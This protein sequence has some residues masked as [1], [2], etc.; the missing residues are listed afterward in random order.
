[1]H[2]VPKPRASQGELNTMYPLCLSH[3]IL[4]GDLQGASVHGTHAWGFYLF[5]CLFA[6][7]LN[8]AILLDFLSKATGSDTVVSCLELLI[9]SRMGAGNDSTGVGCTVP[10]RI[11]EP[12]GCPGTHKHQQLGNS[13]GVQVDGAGKAGRGILAALRCNAVQCR[14]C[15]YHLCARI[16][17]FSRRRKTLGCCLNY[18]KTKQ[19]NI[20]TGAPLKACRT[21]HLAV[22]FWQK[23]GPRTST[24]RKITSQPDRCP[25]LA[26]D[27][28][29]SLCI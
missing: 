23:W 27:F 13:Q 18:N 14:G 4:Q 8:I 9:I 22:L 17:I 24:P 11:R 29:S 6:S 26:S 28:F 10:S 5:V 2:K 3:I 19:R 1:M 16:R 21:Q 25:G 12:R 15:Y 20:E 7:S